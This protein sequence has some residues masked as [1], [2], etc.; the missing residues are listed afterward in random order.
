MANKHGFW[1]ALT[2][3]NNENLNEFTFAPRA[4][5]LFGEEPQ[6]DGQSSNQTNLDK[7]L[8][9][10]VGPRTERAQSNLL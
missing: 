2:S 8:D 9:N 10:A 4:G 5:R 6:S 1:H 3:Q 7:L